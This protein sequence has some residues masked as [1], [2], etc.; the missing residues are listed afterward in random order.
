MNELPI[1]VIRKS[2]LVFFETIPL[3][4]RKKKREG[5]GLSDEA[6]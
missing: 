3:G 2:A 1:C 4:F 6:A 5:R